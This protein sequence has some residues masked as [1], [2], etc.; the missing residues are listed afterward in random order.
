MAITNGTILCAPL[1]IGCRRRRRRVLWQDWRTLEAIATPAIVVATFDFCRPKRS[2]TRC[3]RFWNSR[4]YVRY[5]RYYD[6]INAARRDTPSPFALPEEMGFLQ[7][8][9]ALENWEETNPDRHAA[10]DMNVLGLYT[11]TYNFT[12]PLNG[13]VVCFLLCW[14]VV[15]K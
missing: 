13:L 9:C 11:E 2:G 12:N 3:A 1:R 5:R 15:M 6:R 8:L 7:I 10:M 14:L 4:R